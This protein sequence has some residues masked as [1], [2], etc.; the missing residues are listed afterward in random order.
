MAGTTKVTR[1]LIAAACVLITATP[2]LAAAKPLKFEI[3]AGSAVDALAQFGQ[4]SG[5]QMF[6]ARKAVE[7]HQVRAVTGEYEPEAALALLLEDT[8]LRFEFVNER[9]V[10]VVSE[11]GG[12][13][14]T[15]D[16]PA[17]EVEEII[18]TAQ[19]RLENIQDVPVPVTAISGES[20][21]STNQTRLQDYY[22]RIPGLT[23]TPGTNGRP[24][25]VI[26]GITTDAAI[27]PTVGMTVDDVPYGASTGLGGGTIALDIDPSD[28]ARVEVLRGPQG[29][30]YG[31]SNLGG[32]LKF[33]TID[34][35]TDG[36]TG[37]VQASLSGVHGGDE[38]G[39]GVR[40]AINLPAG[41][42]FAVRASGFTRRDPGY[43]DNPVS[44]VDGV[45]QGRVDGGRVTALW[46]ASDLWSVKLGAMLNDS[47]TEGSPTR[48]VAPGLADL[49]TNSLIGTGGF[50]RKTQV[51]S[52]N[53]SGDFGAAELVSI[54]A[55]T[56]DDI[57]SINDVT[58][59]SVGTS[60]QTR[61]NVRG[62]LQTDDRQTRKF[63]QEL[64][65]SLPLGERV[66]WLAGAFYGDEESPI[67]QIA[68]AADASTGATVGTLL[69]L[70]ADTTYEEYAAFTNLTFRITERFD[71]QV[72][73]RYSRIEQSFAQT[74]TGPLGGGLVIPL[75]ETRANA[76][77]Y[78]LTPRLRISPDLMVYARIASGYRAGGPNANTQEAASAGTPVEYRPDK[79]ENYEIGVK[80]SVLA[81]TL[82]FDASVYYIDWQDVQL[83]AQI[84]NRFSYL[85][86]GGRARSQGVELS[87]STRPIAG[88]GISAAVA[89]NDA[90]LAE[91]LPLTSTLMA[92]AGDR[93]PNSARLSGNLAVDQEFPIGN[94]VT[95]HVGASCSY[96]GNRLSLFTTSFA[97]PRFDSPSYTQ[98]DLRAG[99][100][101]DSWALN[102]FVNNVADKRGVLAGTLVPSTVTYIQ[103]RTAGLSIEKTF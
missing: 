62:A 54:S 22:A 47:R 44:G 65:L 64:R 37:R 13:T 11:G 71:V 39:Y 53:V 98:I 91:D 42:T 72:G 7:G 15:E 102:L 69:D 16:R 68:Y 57:L 40:G 55:Y 74:N 1:L 50:E 66:D 51:Y 23:Y 94:A 2:G 58:L 73:G 101:F 90:E 77:T 3:A 81:G 10:T 82:S 99:A 18:I 93:L 30:L 4:Q 85:L 88:F 63:T 14:Q 12:S 26:R 48:N 21:A 52:A 46:R 34:P 33:V 67:R 8:G 25:L 29:T 61:F 83:R 97:T 79:T 87:L 84:Q 24:Q 95:G 6:F 5:L 32:L 89:Y 49:E 41:D 38:A 35:S 60:A 45:N 103:P 36:V 20:L 92:R 70:V 80:G 31:A 43:I 75:R 59:T 56:I 78:L 100:S 27:N 17:A 76:V 96:V 86:N 9:T 19:K 28:L